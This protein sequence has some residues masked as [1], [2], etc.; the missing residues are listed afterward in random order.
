MLRDEAADR[1]SSDMAF[2]WRVK[3]KLSLC[4]I[5]HFYMK[6]YGQVEIQLH[7]FLTSALGADEWLASRPH[8]FIPEER[9][10]ASLNG[11]TCQRF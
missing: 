11:S 3:R 5:M 2:A 4:L 9:V 7:S 1:Q 10:S 8:R 6:A